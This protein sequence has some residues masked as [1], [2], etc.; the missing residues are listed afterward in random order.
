MPKTKK[1]KYFK[2]KAEII[3]VKRFSCTGCML[4]KLA[5]SCDEKWCGNESILDVVE[6]KEIEKEDYK[7]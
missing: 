6:V 5:T 1:H 4:D 2:I 3:P 7:T